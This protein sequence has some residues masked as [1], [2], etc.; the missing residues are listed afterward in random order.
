MNIYQK[1]SIILAP[2]AGYTDIPYRHSARRFGCKYAFTEM[3]DAHSIVYGNRKSL[4]YLDKHPDEKWL[5][6]QLLGS[7]PEILSKAVEAID[8]FKYRVIDFN[9]GC[10]VPKV[11]KKGDGA[12]LAKNESLALRALDSIVRTSQLPVTAKIRILSETNIEE[13]VNFAKKLE[14]CGIQALTIH[15]RVMKAFYS[16]PVFSNII[17][18]VNDELSIQVI[19]N[20]GVMDYSSACE[21]R[22]RTNCDTIMVA[23]GA[24]GNPW[25]F[26][27][28]SNNENFK[29]PTVAE[30]ANEIETH[31]NE[32]INYYGDLRALRI[33]RKMILDYLKG[34]G[35]SGELKSRI[36]K[37]TTQDDF[38]DYMKI[39]REGPKDGYWSWLK[40]NPNAIKQLCES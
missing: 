12:A 13:T 40:S 15:G 16:G 6:V 18:A 10:P 9:L 14:N 26:D 5:G 3:I 4:R 32:M 39:I 31:I 37:L 23:R 21:L 36:S 22:K 2:L 30:F 29:Y 24:M 34:R 1:N 7:D 20:G 11:A 27:E 28:I 38:D 25:I 17:K 8:G 19:A 33:S 35:F